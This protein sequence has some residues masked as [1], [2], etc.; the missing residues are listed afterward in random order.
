[1]NESEAKEAV[2]LYEKISA[3]R[4]ELEHLGLIRKDGAGVVI[5]FR[6]KG[7]GYA[8]CEMMSKTINCGYG[9]LHTSTVPAFLLEHFE[10]EAMRRISASER[11]L[12][13]L[14]CSA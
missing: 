1:M 6:G 4:K 7:G 9:N 14:G 8:S 10:K 2:S 12:A 3:D 11:R 13:Q 5:T